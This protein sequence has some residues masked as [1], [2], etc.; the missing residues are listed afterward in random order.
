MMTMSL[1]LRQWLLLLVTAV[2]AAAQQPGAGSGCRCH[3]DWGTGE[4]F[5]DA[6][7]TNRAHRRGTVGSLFRWS[8][9]PSEYSLPQPDEPLVAERPDFTEASSVVGLGVLQVEGGYTYTSN[10]DDGQQ[11]IGHSYPETLFRYGVLANWLEARLAFNFGNE[12]VT[13][14]LGSVNNRGGDDLYLGL[15]IGLTPQDGWRPEMALIPQMT[16]PTGSERRSDEKVLPGINWVYSWGVNDFVSIGGSTQF[17]ETVDQQTRDGYTQWAQSTTVVYSLTDRLG[18]YTEYFGFY[19]ANADSDRPENYFNGGLTYL[20][21][22]N[23][24]YDI[25]GGMGLNDDADDYF[26]GTGLTIRFR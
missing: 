7:R 6:C 15:K 13:T 16:V 22:D 1:S 19:P 17:N 4:T 26:V 12:R 3:A 21:T 20:I 25:R 11:T 5:S 23:V 9:N 2:P 8:G 14:S 10:D 18:A 24:Q